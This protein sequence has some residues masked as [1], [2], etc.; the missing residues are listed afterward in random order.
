MYC[1][2]FVSLDSYL[3]ILY[4]FSNVF[5]YSYFILLGRPTCPIE[6]TSFVSFKLLFVFPSLYL[7]FHFHLFD[8]FFYSF[9]IYY[10]FSFS[11]PTLSI[12][13]ITFHVDFIFLC[14]FFLLFFQDVF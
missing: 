11:F 1:S 14:L 6:F 2:I 5:G 9:F 3:G 12:V 13:P 10:L 7:L 4:C 8:S